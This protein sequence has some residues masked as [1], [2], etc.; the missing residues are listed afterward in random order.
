MGFD[1]QLSGVQ[2]FG[3]VLYL[4]YPGFCSSADLAYM[5]ETEMSIDPLP[6]DFQGKPTLLMFVALL[7]PLLLLPPGRAVWCAWSRILPQQTD[8]FLLYRQNVLLLHRL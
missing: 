5:P 1:R 4:I 6:S 2:F 3:M 7:T 8:V